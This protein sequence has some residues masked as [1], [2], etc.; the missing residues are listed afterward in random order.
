MCLSRLSFSPFSNPI[1]ALN[2]FHLQHFDPDKT[3]A[4]SAL[5]LTLPTSCSALKLLTRIA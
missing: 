4:H 1:R 5:S 3:D 2:E